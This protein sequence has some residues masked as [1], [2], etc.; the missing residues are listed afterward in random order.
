L[1]F[2]SPI[3]AAKRPGFEEKSSEDGVPSTDFGENSFEVEAP[4]TKFRPFF[5]E[6]A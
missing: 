5:S 2:K 4:N 3:F 1:S 6:L